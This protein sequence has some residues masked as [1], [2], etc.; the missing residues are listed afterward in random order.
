MYIALGH[1]ILAVIPEG[2]YPVSRPIERQSKTEVTLSK[3][4]DPTP[5]N[6][7][8]NKTMNKQDL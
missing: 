4:R 2:R 8:K 5:I 7:G 1:K 6:K 3:Q